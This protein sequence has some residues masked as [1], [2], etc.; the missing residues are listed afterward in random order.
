MKQQEFEDAQ[1]SRQKSG[2]DPQT[3]EDGGDKRMEED[4]EKKEDNG[5]TEQDKGED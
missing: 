4:E 3:G 2:D 1:E 5:D